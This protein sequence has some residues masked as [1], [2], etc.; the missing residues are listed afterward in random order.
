MAYHRYSLFAC[1][2]VVCVKEQ[3]QS[4]FIAFPDLRPIG[5]A[6]AVAS[7]CW[8]FPFAFP[9]WHATCL[10]HL[11]YFALQGASLSTRA[12]HGLDCMNRGRQMDQK[13]CHLYSRLDCNGLNPFTAL[14]FWASD[15][16][17]FQPASH[18]ICCHHLVF[19]HFPVHSALHLHYPQRLWYAE[20][21]IEKHTGH[22]PEESWA[23][24]IPV[25]IPG[26]KTPLILCWSVAIVYIAENKNKQS[27]LNSV[28][29]ALA[30]P[31]HSGP[32]VTQCITDTIE[33]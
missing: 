9:L 23:W 15:L 7:C 17:I 22:N 10:S 33:S 28:C 27:L 19:I 32:S 12:N 1:W 30:Y 25:E 4:C 6:G 29:Y 11:T 2:N 5:E 20:D 14:V 8:S 24:F 26:L 31:T 16:F 21:S 13:V 18:S 3:D